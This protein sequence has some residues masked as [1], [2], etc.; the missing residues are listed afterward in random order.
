MGCGVGDSQQSTGLGGTGPES[1]V[2]PLTKE[3]AQMRFVFTVE[4]EATRVEGKFATKD[5]LA[6]QIQE[7]L[8]SADPSQLDGDDGG[9]YSIDDWTVSRDEEAE[10][11]KRRAVR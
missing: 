11:P 10:K 1:P 5:E 3:G 6:D 7:A 2:P 4:I 9:Q 8:E